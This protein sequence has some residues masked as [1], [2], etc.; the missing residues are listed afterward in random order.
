MFNSNIIVNC[1]YYFLNIENILVIC[2]KIIIIGSF[3]AN[4]DAQDIG[5]FLTYLQKL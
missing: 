4:V 3:K 2:S 5:L 1:L